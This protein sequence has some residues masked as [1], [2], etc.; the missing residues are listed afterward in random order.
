[1]SYRLGGDEFA[2]LLVGAELADAEA[3]LARTIRDRG[4]VCPVLRRYGVQLSFGVAQYRPGE[5]SEAFV[6][7]TDHAMYAVKE[8]R[9][10]AAMHRNARSD[11]R[12][13][14]PSAAAAVP[15]KETAG[16][17]VVPAAVPE[18]ARQAASPR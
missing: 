3:A 10:G 11:P 8:G 6:G 13:A 17:P 14:R 4:P 1:M 18:R 2:V 7:R 16:P 15:S 5:T 12:P 9:K